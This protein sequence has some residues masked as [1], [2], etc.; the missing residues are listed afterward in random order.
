MSAAIFDVDR[1]LLDGMSGYRFTRWL[2]AK[3]YLS[4]H[5]KLRVA[6]SFFLYRSG[7]KPITELVAVGVTCLAGMPALHVDELADQCVDEVLWP[8]LFTEA[9]EKIAEH[10]AC[11]D[12]TCLASGSAQPLIAALARRVGADAGIG[13]AAM[14]DENGHYLPTVKPPFSYMAGKL[15]LVEQLL[16]EKGLRLEEAALYTDNGADL[17]L[18]RRVA[19]PFAVNPD[20]GLKQKALEQEW[21]ILTWETRQNPKD[22]YTGT[23]WPIKS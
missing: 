7:L 20:P 11:K 12:F 6:K 23:S 2:W 1:T 15:E 19:R 3:G 16:G 5:S 18:C 9:V 13:T 14:I 10:A 8:L 21:P 4:A 22:R 17:P